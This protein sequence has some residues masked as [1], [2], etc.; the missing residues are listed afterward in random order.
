MPEPP[1][2]T[3]QGVVQ[4]SIPDGGGGPAPEKGAARPVVARPVVRADELQDDGAS[5]QDRRI[6]TISAVL[7]EA[8]ADV[9]AS[10]VVADAT[11]VSDATDTMPGEV[12]D[13]RRPEELTTLSSSTFN[14]RHPSSPLRGAWTVPIKGDQ[15]APPQSPLGAP[16]LGGSP[17][18]S[19]TH[20]ASSSQSMQSEGYTEKTP[21]V[22]D[23]KPS[24]DALVQRDPRRSRAAREPKWQWRHRTGWKDYSQDVSTEIEK[25]FQKGDSKARLKSGKTG[26]QP[27]EIFF[28][29]GTIKEGDTWTGKIY[30][31]NH[32]EWTGRD[33]YVDKLQYDAST[34]SKRQVQRVGHDPWWQ[35]L[36]RGARTYLRAWE[37][38]RP[39][40]E[41]YDQWSLRGDCSQERLVG[42]PH[43]AETDDERESVFHEDKSFKGSGYFQAIARSKYFKTWATLLVGVNAI[44]QAVELDCNRAPVLSDADIGFQIVEHSFCALF[45]LEILVR[46]MAYVST[47]AALKDAWFRFDAILVFMM[48]GELWFLPIFLL[49]IDGGGSNAAMGNFQVLRMARL[50]RLT[51]MTR[52]FKSAPELITLIKGISTAIRPVTYTLILLMTLLYVFGIVFRSQIRQGSYLEERY[53]SSVSR[54]VS[55][56]LLH[57]TFL[58]SVALV[59]EEIREESL[60]LLGIFYLCILLTNLTV[61][62]M[63]IGITCEMVSEVKKCEEERLAKADLTSKLSDILLVYDS[64]GNN[65]LQR[66]EFDL[67]MKN[68]EVIEV[69]QHF[70][71]D[72]AGFLTLAEVLYE[73]GSMVAEEHQGRPST[74]SSKPPSREIREPALSFNEILDLVVRLKGDNT[75]TVQDIVELRKYTK[76]RLEKLETRVLKRL[77]ESIAATTGHSD[78]KVVSRTQTLAPEQMKH[79]TTLTARAGEAQ[80]L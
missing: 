16:P 73:A 32:N 5:N 26:K 60:F 68:V 57:A 31:E 47:I 38:S 54:A 44:W 70:E 72:Y 23:F 65:S 35:R 79:R 17:L 76:Q 59:A 36:S 10:Q 29:G 8:P 7:D 78:W 6:S 37:T 49:I 39:R 28:A 43:G 20:L 48:M 12:A 25:A 9:A 42:S 67:F 24:Q 56:C 80:L 46:F 63:L 52:L 33:F 51:R 58:D 71:V 61:L 2:F 77:D 11:R 19:P 1:P 75:P 3:P 34:E 14:G 62:N 22:P 41:N 66:H 13:D 55:T 4:F 50:V 21:I 45:A 18:K 27:L 53:F 69:L 40:R 64:D 15:A 74:H 30:D